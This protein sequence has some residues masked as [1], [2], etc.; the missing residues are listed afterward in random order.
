MSMYD[1]DG[2]TTGLSLSLCVKDLSRVMSPST[3]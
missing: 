3:G 1:A 2:Y